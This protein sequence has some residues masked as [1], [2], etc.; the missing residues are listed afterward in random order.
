MHKL[1]QS[2][3]WKPY[4]PTTLSWLHIS[5]FT[6]HPYP[7]LYLLQ[8]LYTFVLYVSFSPKGRMMQGFCRWQ[9]R[10]RKKE[11]EMAKLY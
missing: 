1:I 6:I 9:V 7:E 5:F 11:N 8:P 2:K 4:I 10:L 3:I